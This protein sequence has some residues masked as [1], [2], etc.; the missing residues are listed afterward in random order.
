[1]MFILK[2]GISAFLL[3]P[4]IEILGLFAAALWL[5]V[6][7]R[8]LAA[9]LFAIMAAFLWLTSIAPV[10][11]RLTATLE[12]GLSIPTPLRGDVI[13]LLGG[14]S[15]EGARDLSGSGSPSDESLARIVTAVRAQRILHVPV[16]VSGGRVFANRTPEAHLMKRFLCDL[17]VPPEKVIVEERSRDTNEN[18][19]YSAQICAR[20]GFRK[21]LLVTSAYHMRRALF[22]FARQ[23]LKVVPLPVNL[24][25]R[26]SRKYIWIDYLPSF[27][28]QYRCC[29][30]FHEYLGLLYYRLAL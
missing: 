7:K 26:Q 19:I 8:R 23:H 15:F 14:G 11:D 30:A 16:I 2:K 4:G 24:V 1:M 6:Q 9:A 20:H 3:P 25:P 28:E 13:I 12:S 17:G 10:T 27:A 22:V 29:I 18:A 21:A 5:A